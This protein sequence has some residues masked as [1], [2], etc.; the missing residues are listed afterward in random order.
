MGELLAKILEVITGDNSKG[1]KRLF[2]VVVILLPIF[3]IFGNYF[4]GNIRLEQKV[5]ILKEL[6]SINESEIKNAQLKTYYNELVNS[7]IKNDLPSTNN[8][9]ISNENKYDFSNTIIVWK[10][11]SGSILGI[12]V[13]IVAVFA[14]YEKPILKIVGFLLVGI[15]ASI[16]GGLGLLIPTFDPPMINYIGYPILQL[17][18]L[19]IGV[20]AYQKKKA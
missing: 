9:Q 10:F 7:L 13:M 16:I 15:F 5:N 18:L 17:I 12:L 8:I 14:K 11:L 19:V 1:I 6:S 2:L 4:Y 20:T 3:L